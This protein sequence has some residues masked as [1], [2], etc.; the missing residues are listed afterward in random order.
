MDILLDDPKNFT[1]AQGLS[2]STRS[3]FSSCSRFLGSKIVAFLKGSEVA[4]FRITPLPQTL[5]LID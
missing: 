1:R 4:F 2:G 5:D 3:V